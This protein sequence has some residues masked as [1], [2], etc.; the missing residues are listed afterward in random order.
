MM[1]KEMEKKRFTNGFILNYS[2]KNGRK[3]KLLKNFVCQ[4]LI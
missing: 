2:N 1:K 4:Q 3:R